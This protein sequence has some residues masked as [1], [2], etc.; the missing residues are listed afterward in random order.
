MASLLSKLSAYA[1]RNRPEHLRNARRGEHLAY[2]YLK[3]RGFQIVA[4]NY[5]ARAGR[6][7]VDLFG[8]DDG[9]L[10]CVEVKTRKNADFGRPEE[11]VTREKRRH[12]IR[13]ANEYAKRVGWNPVL[14]RYDIVGVTLEPEVKIDHFRSAFDG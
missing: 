14:I 10:V 1:D 6:G 9:Y 2:D 4:T 3:K 8:Y 11:F 12:L 5:Q 7:E 13:T